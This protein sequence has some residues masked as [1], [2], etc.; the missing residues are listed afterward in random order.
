[1]N[2]WPGGFTVTETAK[3]YSPLRRWLRAERARDVPSPIVARLLAA[4]Y[5]DMICGATAVFGNRVVMVGEMPRELAAHQDDTSTDETVY[6]TP[7]KIGAFEVE[8][9]NVWPS[10][11]VHPRFV[12]RRVFPR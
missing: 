12:R 11:D 1:M 2:L 5:A 4:H 8:N 3:G 7:G 9:Y 6:A 10:G